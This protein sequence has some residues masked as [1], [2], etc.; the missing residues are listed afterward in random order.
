M[1]DRSKRDMSIL[2]SSKKRPDMSSKKGLDFKLLKN[3][4][5]INKR[6]FRVTSSVLE[7]V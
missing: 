5:I 4:I 2:A 3:A 1:L 7:F 6:T